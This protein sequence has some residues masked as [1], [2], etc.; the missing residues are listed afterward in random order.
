MKRRE[1]IAGLGSAAVLPVV[2]RGQEA[3]LPIVGFMNTTDTPE[4]IRTAFRQGLKERG[5]DEG[6]NVIVEYRSAQYQRDRLSALADEFVRRNVAAIAATGGIAVATAA[7]AATATIPI[8]FEIGSD[9]VEDGLVPSL[10][11]PGANITG[12]TSLVFGLWPKLFDLMVKIRPNSR[13]FAILVTSLDLRRVEQIKREVQPAADA[14]GRKVLVMRAST[15]Q[16]ID[17]A[18]PALARE[19]VDALVITASVLANVAAEQ[20]AALSARYAIPAIY[21]FRESA[22]AGGLM[23]YGIKIGRIVSLG[24]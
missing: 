1:F 9:P 17:A 7:K 13:V 22:V 16:E 19:G 5:F 8:I 6:R 4:Y 10:N 21:A 14:I 12:V 23:S 24:R 18:F 2:A 15:P 20:L 11:R 3:R